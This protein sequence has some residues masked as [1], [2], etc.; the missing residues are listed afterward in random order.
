MNNK[1]KD[2][3]E[4]SQNKND[5]NNIDLNNNHNNNF[6]TNQNNN[7]INSDIEIAQNTSINLRAIDYNTTTAITTATVFENGNKMV[8]KN[9]C[10]TSK[11]SRPNLTIETNIKPSNTEN[12]K[13]MI[14]TPLSTVSASATVSVS[15]AIAATVPETLASQSQYEQRLLKKRFSISDLPHRR[16][17]LE[18]KQESIKK[19]QLSCTEIPENNNI[20]NNNNNNN[21]NNSNNIKNNSQF[22]ST[23]PSI[24][25]NSRKLKNKRRYSYFIPVNL[26]DIFSDV[27]SKAINAVK[28]GKAKLTYSRR[29]SSLAKMEEESTTSM[30]INTDINKNPSN[31]SL[32][33]PLELIYGNTSS[34]NRN[35]NRNGNR[36][37]NKNDYSNDN[38]NYNST[39]NSIASSYFSSITPT[40]S[41][42]T[43][44]TTTSTTTTSRKHHHQLLYSTSVQSNNFYEDKSKENNYYP[45][46][47]NHH[48]S[49]FLKNKPILE[50]DF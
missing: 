21:N 19:K 20:N 12:S 23:S 48:R 7:S 46:N 27:K 22:S 38:S 33:S 18:N 40:T 36:N 50:N 47:L 3:A 43:I 11:N 2:N 37:R 10:L 28:E 17:C 6:S 45:L 14:L 24:S 15:T 4:N 8:A 39:S 30:L 13:T 49:S 42:S 41:T 1:D 26:E 16:R 29:N 9:D 34:I 44:F 5:I 35:G 32:K 31:T 25:S